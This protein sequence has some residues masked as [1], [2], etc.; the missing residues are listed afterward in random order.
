MI[1]CNYTFDVDISWLM[2]DKDILK[3]LL[4][5]KSTMPYRL[6]PLPW[7]SRNHTTFRLAFVAFRSPTTVANGAM[8][9]V[10]GRKTWT[11][12]RQGRPHSGGPGVAPL[13]LQQRPNWRSIQPITRLR[14]LASAR[15]VGIT[16]ML[17]GAGVR[18]RS[19]RKKIFRPLLGGRKSWLF[20]C[21]E[22]YELFHAVYC[23]MRQNHQRSVDTVVR[24]LCCSVRENE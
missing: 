2:I 7:R 5:T 19:E 21:D 17:M 4:P 10:T 18:E 13:R 22:Q 3:P 11:M 1:L 6:V 16:K 14:F 23:Q 24:L 12:L 20:G 8:M 15:S 9:H